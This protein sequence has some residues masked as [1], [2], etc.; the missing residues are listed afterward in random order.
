MST[1]PAAND[2]NAA[3]SASVSHDTDACPRCAVP[4]V[5]RQ[6][7]KLIGVICVVRKLPAGDPCWLARLIGAFVSSEHT[8][9]GLCAMREHR[10]C[11]ACA[12]VGGRC[13]TCRESACGQCAAATRICSGCK[14]LEDCDGADCSFCDAMG[15]GD[16]YGRML[17][18]EEEGEE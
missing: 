12:N 3:G 10:A 13:A 6:R 18:E 14:H 16:D 7:L 1:A 15:F 9:F 5:T 17:R 2:D 4:D 11:D 8:D